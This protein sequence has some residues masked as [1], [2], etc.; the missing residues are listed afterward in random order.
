MLSR[1][2]CS[3]RTALSSRRSV[4]D[5]KKKVRRGGFRTPSETDEDADFR[6]NKR[7]R[8]TDDGTDG[9]C[10]HGRARGSRHAAHVSAVN[11]VVFNCVL[12]TIAVHG[13]GFF[14]TRSD[15]QKACR[16]NNDAAN[17]CEKQSYDIVARHVSPR[18]DFH[19]VSRDR[20]SG[21]VD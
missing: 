13:R 12:I 21:R 3:R 1:S 6:R 8:V 19:G 20:D 9:T 7:S 17:P 10:S 5:K 18:T 15:R 4:N 2:S 14:H 16:A 11:V